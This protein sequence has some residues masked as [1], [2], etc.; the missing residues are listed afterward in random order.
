MKTISKVLLVDDEPMMR[1]I[2]AMS[3]ERVGKFTVVLAS[4]GLD[5]MAVAEREK[6][7][8]ILLDVMMPNMDGLATLQKLRASEATSAIP[9]IFLTGKTE[10]QEVDEYLAAG[11][12]GVIPKPFDPMTLPSQIHEILSTKTE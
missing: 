10:Q 4:N 8:L 7:D 3:L 9:V 12:V 6:P 11:A 2:G 1:R 5:A